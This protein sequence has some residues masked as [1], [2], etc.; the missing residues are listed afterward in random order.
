MSLDVILTTLPFGGSEATVARWLVVPGAAVVRGQP[1]LVVL[2][3]CAEVVLP[4]PATGKLVASVAEGA[5]IPVGGA[6]A[7]QEV[8]QPTRV[9][10]L[11]RR[12][13]QAHGLNVA[14][15]AGS[16]P[17]GRVMRCDVVQAL[18]ADKPIVPTV[19]QAVAPVA[20]DDVL[21]PIPSS[22]PL[23]AEWQTV[24]YAL[25]TREIISEPGR[26]IE[27]AMV[28]AALVPVLQQMPQLAGL[29]Q[30]DGLAMR[31]RLHVAVDG[32]LVADAQDLNGRGLARAL[33]TGM[34]DLADAAFEVSF[35]VGWW[36]GGR[37]AHL[38]G[39]HVGATTPRAVVVEDAHGER[40]AIRNVAL[41]T[42]RYDARVATYTEADTFLKRVCTALPAEW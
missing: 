26:I 41:L 3:E 6:L 17:G 40:L 27:R 19:A 39:L 24:P 11:A 21:P 5:T 33:A 34:T 13:A 38:P 15:L 22:T 10:P 7:Q 16:G 9:S 14:T 35:G 18:G 12:V 2:T 36:A 1:L 23:P 4:A 25:A 31:R 32:R 37:A 30:Q 20:Q 42:L 28:L 8:A 29:L